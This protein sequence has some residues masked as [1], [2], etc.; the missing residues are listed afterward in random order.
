MVNKII[1][2]LHGLRRTVKAGG[3]EKNDLH[4]LEE[5]VSLLHADIVQAQERR[6][7]KN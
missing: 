5:L 2:Y 6:G 7:R 1:N 3:L 4:H